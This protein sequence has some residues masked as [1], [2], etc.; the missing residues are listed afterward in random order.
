VIPDAFFIPSSDLAGLKTALC[1]RI[2]AIELVR[3]EDGRA[4]LGLLSQL[5]PGTVIEQCGDGFNERTV[6]VR[7]DG[8]VYFVFCED[9]EA[10]CSHAS[11]SFGQY[12]T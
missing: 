9:L 5:G 6:K 11:A 7:A 3:K 4:K 10:Q 1:Q 2:S 12:C 8:H